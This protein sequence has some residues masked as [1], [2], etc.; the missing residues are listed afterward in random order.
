[1]ITTCMKTYLPACTLRTAFQSKTRLYSLFRFRDGIP[2]NLRSHIVYKFWCSYCNTNYYGQTEK[3]LLV[4]SAEYLG[5]TPLPRKRIKNF[6][7]PAI[8]EQFFS[9]TS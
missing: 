2:K 4:H 8:K 6:K 5:L 3:Y 7:K 1:M 9:N